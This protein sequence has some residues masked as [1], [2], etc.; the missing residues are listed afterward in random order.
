MRP[1]L[2]LVYGDLCL[3]CLSI[4]PVWQRLVHELE[5]LGVGFATIHSSHESILARKL[6]ISTIPTIIGLADGIAKQ[7]KESSLNLIKVGTFDTS[8]SN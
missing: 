5:P 7:F 3:P 4:E 6:S 2:I 8:T 1:Y